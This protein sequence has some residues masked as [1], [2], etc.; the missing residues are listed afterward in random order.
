M[1]VDCLSNVMNWRNQAC[2]C[3]A[4]P[5]WRTTR[6]AKLLGPTENGQRARARIRHPRGG[7]TGGDGLDGLLQS[8]QAAFIAGL[9]QSDAVR[10]TL[11]QGT[12]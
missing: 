1:T 7:K 2:L 8:S 5:R 4:S 6:K 10:A 11:V 3:A 12:A 9:P